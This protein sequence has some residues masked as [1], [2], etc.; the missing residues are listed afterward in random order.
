MKVDN[1]LNKIV[2]LI[3]ENHWNRAKTLWIIS[4]SI[5]PVNDFTYSLFGSQVDYFVK[6]MMKHQKHK[7]ICVNENCLKFNSSTELS[8]LLLKKKHNKKFMLERACSS[9]GL[10]CNI[11]FLKKT[12]GVFMDIANED[13]DSDNNMSYNNDVNI[14]DI[15]SS[16]EIDDQL[17]RLLCLTFFEINH[18]RSLFFLNKIFYVV[19]DLDC[20]KV[21]RK[22]PGT[23]STSFCFFYLS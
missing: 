20:S 5:K 2:E 17:F 14:L 8:T 16:L 23:I 22:L 3:E 18:F 19:D 6:H 4:N 12:F 13:I 21:G 11:K 15:P 7:L 10:L 1:V 9:C